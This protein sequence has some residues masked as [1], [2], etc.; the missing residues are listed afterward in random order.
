MFFIKLNEL[1]SYWSM[2]RIV[3]LR[4]FILSFDNVFAKIK[5]LQTK[6]DT[7]K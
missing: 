4:Q 5:F 2:K 3:S 7:I 1:Y 6:L